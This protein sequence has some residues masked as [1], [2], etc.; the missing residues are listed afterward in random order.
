VT[1]SVPVTTG[2]TYH[3]RNES[4]L[5]TGAEANS[6]TATKSG[7]YELEISNASGCTA[8]TL[9]VT[10]TVDRMPDKPVLA[11]TNYTAGVCPGVDPIRL[12]ISNTGSGYSYMWIK[13]GELQYND[14]LK[15]IEF[16]EKGIYKV[17]AELGKCSIESE[18]FTITLPDA[19]EK[20]GIYIR[21]PVVWYMAASTRTASHYQWYRNDEQIAG[22]TKYIYVANKTL[23]TYKV[24]VGNQNEC[25]TMSDDITIPV[26]LSKMT[27]FYVPKEYLVG[28]DKDLAES[29]RL[30]PNPTTGVFTVEMENSISGEIVIGVI[31]EQ[32]KEIRNI[33]SEKTTDHFITEI[34]LSDEPK[35][36]Y[37]IKL[38]IDNYLETKKVIIE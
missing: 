13:N 9:P 25:Y 8:R 10:I 31:T 12:S 30:Y 34:D 29:I 35:G 1:L 11:S 32:G 20:P 22:A 36:V 33:K 4:G 37:F 28:E 5:I 17:R 26:P 19:P 38:R 16:Y 18:P 23:G 7:T 27:N 15:Y 2:Y 24:A 14:T 3:W 21:G 6:Y